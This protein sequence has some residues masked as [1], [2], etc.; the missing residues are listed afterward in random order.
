MDRPKGS[1][2]AAELALILPAT[3]QVHGYVM[4]MDESDNL[5]IEVLVEIFGYVSGVFGTYHIDNESMVE[6]HQ[7]CCQTLDIRNGRNPDIC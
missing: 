6:D 7:G 4:G 3:G 2:D 1:T 5:P